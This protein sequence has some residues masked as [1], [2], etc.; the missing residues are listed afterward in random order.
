[1]PNMTNEHKAQRLTSASRKLA[2][3]YDAEGKHDTA[4]Q[5]RSIAS[6]PLESLVRLH[7]IL[8]PE[9]RPLSEL[10]KEDEQVTSG[11]HASGTLR[12]PPAKK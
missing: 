3:Q 9:P 1:M 7:D 6:L 10:L 8:D 11:P 12:L 5:V 2:E 4:A